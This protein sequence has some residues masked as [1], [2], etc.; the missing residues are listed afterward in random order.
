MLEKTIT[1]FIINFSIVLSLTKVSR[2]IISDNINDLYF[3][4]SKRAIF[5][6]YLTFD[7]NAEFSFLPYEVYDIIYEYAMGKDDFICERS[8]I[9]INKTE[10]D[11]IVCNEA[12]LSFFDNFNFITAKYAIKVPYK[13]LFISK[14]NLYY[15]RFI[16]SRNVEHIVFDKELIDYMDIEFLGDDNFIIN[17]KECYS[18]LI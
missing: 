2:I 13:K 1:L 12:I 6:T 10:Y 11:A 17:N 3:Y 15:L 8:K 5:G 4:D 7:K 16:T 9:D 18:E 14:D